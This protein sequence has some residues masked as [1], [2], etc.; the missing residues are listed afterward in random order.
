M[1]HTRCTRLAV[2]ALAGVATGVTFVI[3]GFGTPA[4]AASD[5]NFN[6]NNYKEV[7]TTV[8]GTTVKYRAYENIPYVTNPTAKGTQ[9]MSVYVPEAYY[10]NKT[11]NGYSEKTAPI[12]F[13]NGVGGYMPGDIQEPTV[14]NGEANASLAA[15]AHGYVVASPAVRGRT[16]TNENGEYIGK[17]P[18]VIVDLKAAVKY[19]HYNDKVMPGDANKIIS[20]G[21]SAG[22]AVSALLGATGDNPAYDSYLKALGAAPAS[23]AIFAVSAY[24]PITNLD[25]ANSAYEWSYGKLDSYTGMNFGKQLPKAA[26][27]SAPSASAT[28]ST[29]GAPA[30]KAP[31]GAPALPEAAMGTNNAKNNGGPGGPG[32]DFH[33]TPGKPVTFTAADHRLSNILAAQFPAYVNSLQLK[34]EQGRP[35]TLNED[36]TG[37]FLNYAKQFVIQSAND[38][39]KAG[40]DISQAKYLVYNSDHS[41]VIDVNWDA[42][43]KAVGRIKGIGAF[44]SPTADTGENDE[45]GTSTNAQRHF[46]DFMATY[47]NKYGVA[48]ANTVRLMNP[49]DF[50]TDKQ[51]KV[52]PH[53]RIRYGE[54]DN[55]TSPAIPL[56]LATKLRNEG[57]DVNYYA[58][59]NVGHRGDYDLKELFAW[60]DSIVK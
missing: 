37:S 39:L 55:N 31:Q 42:Y 10:H 1:S 5:L 20:N 25:N 44:D 18:A 38:A 45:F 59:W 60:I 28:P 16:S 40:T 48:D 19:L 13:P 43:N 2:T 32:G 27:G 4:Y 52:A 22:G 30:T 51:S 49:M 11:I 21:T 12:F 26:M 15:L 46:T 8:D 57:Y 54:I 9:T 56:I 34:D 35:L 36:G 6:I 50:I 33:P 7:S 17:A 47:D 3:T 53:W 41:K 23:D 58:P 24:C 14:R 29:P